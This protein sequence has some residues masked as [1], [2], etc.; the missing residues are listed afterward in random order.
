M[1]DKTEMVRAVAGFFQ[2]RADE[3]AHDLFSRLGRIEDPELRRRQA[4]HYC[5]RERISFV[6]G[7][8]VTSVLLCMFISV[9]MLDFPLSIKVTAVVALGGAAARLSRRITGGL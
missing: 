5:R 3:A 4:E 9:V 1:E 2:G 6:Y 8:T 7:L